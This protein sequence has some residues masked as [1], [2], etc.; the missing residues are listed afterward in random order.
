[1]R[2][3][4]LQ[5]GVDIVAQNARFHDHR[6]AAGKDHIGHFRVLLQVSHQQLLFLH[7]DLPL[8]DADKLRPA[9][10]ERAIGVAGLS[11]LGEKQDG[12]AVFVL[13]SAQFLS[14]QL[15]QIMLHLP[16]GMGIELGADV[17]GYLFDK[18]FVLALFQRG[19]H[20]PEMCFPK[21]PA[22]REGQHEHRIIGHIVP[23]D[24]LFHHIAV[25]LEGKYMAYHFNLKTLGFAQ[26]LDLGELA[27]IM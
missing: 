4:G 15:R 26:A 10:A 20:F 12:L 7:S 5:Q 17:V 9:E 11:L 16:G 6:I 19:S 21:H 14:V 3:I 22:L 27:K 23:V 2:Q 1:M 13:D 25:G 24:Q 18:R 8:I